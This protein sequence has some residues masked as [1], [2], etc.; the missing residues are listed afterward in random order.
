MIA[1][2][3]RLNDML[4]EV[5]DT[6]AAT[7]ALDFAEYAVELQADLLDPDLRAALAE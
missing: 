2:P 5:D 7:L 6:R 4:G 3:A 1:L